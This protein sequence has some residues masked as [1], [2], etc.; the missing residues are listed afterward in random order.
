ML[1]QHSGIAAA[2]RPA[3][4]RR[5]CRVGARHVRRA[6]VEQATVVAK[7]DAQAKLLYS[8]V[9]YPRARCGSPGGTGFPA[10][11][12]LADAGGCC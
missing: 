2:Q 5:P 7:Q 4:L 10:A 9:R 12:P 3:L 11:L 8:G 1:A 6:A